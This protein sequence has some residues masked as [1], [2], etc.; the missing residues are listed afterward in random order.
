MSFSL[1]F[2]FRIPGCYNAPEETAQRGGGK[3]KGISVNH[4]RLAN[5]DLVTF[6]GQVHKVA[7]VIVF[8]FQWFIQ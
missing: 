3:S 1:I 4:F 2:F 8:H 5:S 6:R 7:T